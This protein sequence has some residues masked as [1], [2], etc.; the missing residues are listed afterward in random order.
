MGFKIFDEQLVGAEMRK[1]EMLI[2]SPFYLG[3]SV[4]EL[5]KIHMSR[6]RYEYFMKKYRAG[7]MRFTGTDR[8]FYWVETAESKRSSSQSWT[9]SSS[10][11]STRRAQC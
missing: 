1:I 10:L 9:T 4:L 2:N 5:S 7:K 6:F 3:F 11:H 8:L